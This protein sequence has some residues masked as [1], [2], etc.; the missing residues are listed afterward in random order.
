[1]PFRRR[2]SRRRSGTRSLPSR[3]VWGGF[4][5]FD[6]NGGISAINLNSGAFFHTWI[7]SP[8]DA[9]DFYDEPTVAR[10]LLA[11]NVSV[12]IA[13]ASV[14]LNYAASVFASIQVVKDDDPSTPPFINQLDS[15]KDYLWYREWFLYHDANKLIAF[16]S[17]ASVSGPQQGQYDIR[18]KRKIPEGYGLSFQCWNNATTIGAF[19]NPVG[20]TTFFTGRFLMLDH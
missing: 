15:T 19:W 3:K 2:S 18:S 9:A 1:M 11:T 12:D 17:V 13:T 7:L 5:T 20:I 14:S 10:I 8:N 4:T 16:P 6:V